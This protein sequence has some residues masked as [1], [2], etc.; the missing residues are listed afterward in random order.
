[1]PMLDRSHVFK[2]NGS[3]MSKEEFEMVWEQYKKTGRTGEKGFR[4]AV[5]EY[6]ENPNIM[7]NWDGGVPFEQ[8]CEEV[9]K[10]SK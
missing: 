1:M 9:E 8:M 5:R 10:E 7:V 4:D 2:P 3:R 6:R